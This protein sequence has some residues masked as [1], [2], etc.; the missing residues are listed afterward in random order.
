MLKLKKTFFVLAVRSSASF[1]EIKLK[2]HGLVLHQ[3]SDA[4]RAYYVFKL[5]V[6]VFA[7]ILASHWSDSSPVDQIS[8][9]IGGE[10]WMCCEVFSVLLDKVDLD[11]D[12]S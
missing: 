5:V 4:G 8:P 7:E 6:F 3:S 2:V 11:L 9:L 12:Y 10:L 1:E